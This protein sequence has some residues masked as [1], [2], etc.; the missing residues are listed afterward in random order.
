M[1]LIT[2]HLRQTAQTADRL[3]FYN[4]KSQKNLSRTKCFSDIIAA[5][6]AKTVF[7]HSN[8]V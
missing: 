6:Q 1:K 3:N 2:E 5:N 8:N 4:N 7:I